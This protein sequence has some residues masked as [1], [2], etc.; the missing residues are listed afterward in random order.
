M[1]FSWQV[2]CGP[3]LELF[4]P[5]SWLFVRQ[6]LGLSDL[7]NWRCCHL[8]WLAN[9]VEW[10]LCFLWDLLRLFSST[11]PYF[12]KKIRTSSEEDDQGQILPVHVIDVVHDFFQLEIIIWVIGKVVDAIIIQVWKV[13]GRLRWSQTDRTVGRSSILSRRVGWWTRRSWW[14]IAEKATTAVTA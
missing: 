6:F 8:S 13:G 2:V 9:C 1:S 11:A 4:L 5:N 12:R 14:N 3:I 7:N 10:H